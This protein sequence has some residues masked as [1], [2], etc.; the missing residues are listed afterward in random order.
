MHLF[1][2]SPELL[3]PVFCVWQLKLVGKRGIYKD[4]E[5][6]EEGG[7]IYEKNGIIYNCAFSIC[8][9]TAGLNQYVIETKTFELPPICENLVCLLVCRSCHYRVMYCL[10]VMLFTIWWNLVGFGDQCIKVVLH[11]GSY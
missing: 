5:L 11:V 1:A 2:C 8:D 6:A 7:K 9:M 4:T 10:T 3:H